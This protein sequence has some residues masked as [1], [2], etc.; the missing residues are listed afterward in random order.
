MVR[1]AR[2][3][4]VLGSAS[5]LKESEPKAAELGRA[6][7]SEGFALLTGATGGL[8]LAA[9]IAAKQTGALVIGVSPAANPTEHEKLFPDQPDVFDAVI[10][11]GFGLKGRNVVL[12]RT[13][14]AVALVG[15]R[16]GTLNEFTIAFDEG[17]IIGV[18]EGSGGVSDR[19]R[20]LVEI[21]KEGTGARMVYSKNPQELAK[22]LGELLRG[23]KSPF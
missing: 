23:V 4:A 19:V 8:S 14:D 11:T 3:I 17:K 21:G 22:K 15:G 7:A 2:T 12:V 10:Y 5:G 16:T 20:E 18:L 6:I 1:R 9:A 13:A